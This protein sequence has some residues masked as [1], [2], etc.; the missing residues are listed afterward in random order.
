MKAL[1]LLLIRIS[2]GMLLVLWGLL[3]VR[4]P[5]TGQGL[6]N[7]YYGGLLDSST[8]Q[9]GLGW[10]EVAL[11]VLII[12]GFLRIIVYPV[13]TLVLG[14]GLV[15]IWK[16]ILDPFGLYLFAEDEKANL[17]FFPSTTVFFATLVLLAFREYDRFSVDALTKR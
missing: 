7:K 17:L 9:L 1:S 16:H 2:T 11:G 8:L 13:Q 6:A 3:R 4:S 5:E 10:A 12:L 15:F 14:V